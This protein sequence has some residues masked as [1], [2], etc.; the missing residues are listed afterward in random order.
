MKI[1]KVL[2]EMYEDMDGDLHDNIIDAINANIELLADQIKHAPSNTGLIFAKWL[3]ENKNILIDL[4]GY[5]VALIDE[6]NKLRIAK[7]NGEE[8]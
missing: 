6:E 5:Y 3:V 2:K 7:E 1:N 4:E 8:I